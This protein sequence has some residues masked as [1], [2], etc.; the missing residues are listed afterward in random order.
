[1]P[2]AGATKETFVISN[3]Y[4][5][6]SILVCVYRAFSR[7]LT[8]RLDHTLIKKPIDLG[9]RKKDCAQLGQQWLYRRTCERYARKNKIQILAAKNSQEIAGTRS[10]NAQPRIARAKKASG[11]NRNVCRRNKE[12][13]CIACLARSTD[14]LL[15]IN[16]GHDR[17]SGRS[18]PTTADCTRRWRDGSISVAADPKR[19]LADSI[20]VVDTQFVDRLD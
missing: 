9:R 14:Y 4:E 3:H 8:H 19:R 20:S 11:Q 1:M 18:W 7:Q 10:S 16:P 13:V 5:C 15:T 17:A 2:A 12:R 6:T